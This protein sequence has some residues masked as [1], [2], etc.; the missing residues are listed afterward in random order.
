MADDFRISFTKS[1]GDVVSDN[2]VATGDLAF[3]NESYERIL[4][5]PAGKLP[6][7][8]IASL[9]EEN[10]N[11]DELNLNK[12]SSTALQFCQIINK[13]SPSGQKILRKEN[14]LNESVLGRI[15]NDD[16]ND[17][18]LDESD[19]RTL[20]QIVL[21]C[22]LYEWKG[23]PSL[24]QTIRNHQIFQKLPFHDPATFELLKENNILSGNQLYLYTPLEKIS[25][26]FMTS[27]IPDSDKRAIIGGVGLAQYA[28][29]IVQ[30]NKKM[31]T[32][33]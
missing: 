14:L 4:P 26:M 12:S 11:F 22:R 17:L 13:I 9:S 3:E 1:Q 5:G 28:R 24:N 23:M 21:Q 31:R 30:R 29:N 25:S 16:I 20:R 15:T 19:L 18:G 27:D 32:A 33:L 7:K 8:M 10:L 2:F 6:E